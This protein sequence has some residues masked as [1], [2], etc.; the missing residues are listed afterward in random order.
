MN[1]LKTNERNMGLV[2][3]E[4]KLTSNEMGM[5]ELQKNLSIA[6][7]TMSGRFL[8]VP[9][10]NV[11]A[12][13][14]E[15]IDEFNNTKKFN[16]IV[17]RKEQSEEPI[18]SFDLDEEVN[19]SKSTSLVSEL[20]CKINWVNIDHLPNS[21]NKYIKALSKII[22][23]SLG[24]KENSD[25]FLISSFDDAPLTNHPRELNVAVN[26]LQKNFV[27]AI[28]GLCTIDFGEC[29]KGYKPELMIFH[30]YKH[31]YLVLNEPSGHGIEARY[32]Y[33]FERI[34]N[35]EDMS[36]LKSLR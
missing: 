6:M 31:A 24:I 12:I 19:I 28:D 35:I 21:N 11:D 16:E 4:E 10:I 3:A 23:S 30:S 9:S 33:R 34:D 25:I 26:F 8:N 2:S 32:I 17:E 20:E 7:R 18:D 1:I 29:I 5:R 15:Y 14:D 27:Q 22:F 36:P 13:P